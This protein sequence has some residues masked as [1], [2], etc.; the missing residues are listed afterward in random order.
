MAGYSSTIPTKVFNKDEVKYDRNIKGDGFPEAT[1][2]NDPLF[3]W[4]ERLPA[5]MTMNDGCSLISVG[6]AREIWQQ[7]GRND[8]IPSVFQA[9]INNIKGMFALSGPVDSTANEHTKP[10][11]QVV[12][13][14]IKAKRHHQESVLN[15]PEDINRWTMDI[16]SWS[17]KT[18]SYGLHESFVP[19]MIDRGVSVETIS[20]FVRTSLDKQRTDIMRAIENPRDLLNWLRTAAEEEEGISYKWALPE[21]SINRIST[22]IYSGFC[23]KDL[24][25][26]NNEIVRIIQTQLDK[27]L[28]SFRIDVPRSTMVLGIADPFGVLKPG[29]IFISFSPGLDVG[30]EQISSPP[31]GAGVLVSRHP[32]LRPS[33]IQKVRYKFYPELEH[34]RNVV[35]FSSKGSFPLAQKLSGGDYDGDRF[36]VSIL[37]DLKLFLI[38]ISFV[39]KRVWFQISR[40]LLLRSITAN[41]RILV[42]RSIKDL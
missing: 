11:V 3:N 38:L 1:S 17:C 34:Y 30:E 42:S 2:F 40:M 14:Q 25:F 21:G 33:D 41:L 39:G 27:T 15:T 7:I 23:P 5:K 37:S 31:S 13:S 18:T 8:P 19:I 26:L 6:A 9:R 29:E 4:D 16:N 24:G 22:L 35:V 32:A 20:N 36:W 12:P 10:W 28:S